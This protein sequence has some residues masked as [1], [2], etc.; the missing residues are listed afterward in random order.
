M[1][2]DSFKHYEDKPNNNFRWKFQILSKKI[3]QMHHS[4]F[5]RVIFK[6]AGTTVS[7]NA[8]IAI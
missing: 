3:Q 7:F 8:T 1:Y 5:C 4:I 2:K 6:T